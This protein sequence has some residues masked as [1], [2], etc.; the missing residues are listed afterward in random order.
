MS[1]QPADHS[2]EYW[3]MR[4]NHE[5]MLAREVDSDIARSVHFQMAARYDE[6]AKEAEAAE[7]E[8]SSARKDER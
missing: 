8:C 6:L 5:R 1:M 4:A 7:V 3:K 2:A